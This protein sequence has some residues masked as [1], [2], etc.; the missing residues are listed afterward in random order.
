MT[1]E[2]NED[3][4]ERCYDNKDEKADR[5]REQGCR[6]DSLVALRRWRVG[7]TIDTVL[8]A[9]GKLMHN[10]ANEPS[11]FL[12]TEML[13]NLPMESV[14]EI[15]HWF[16]KRFSR[17]SAEKK[18]REGSCVW[19]FPKSPTP[20]LKKAHTDSLRVIAQGKGAD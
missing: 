7:I 1:T 19:N 13:Q 8:G 3:H 16:E 4:C 12:V 20:D 11:D 14:Y 6:E 18:R 17:E 15:S 9:R 2:K 5:I 10:K